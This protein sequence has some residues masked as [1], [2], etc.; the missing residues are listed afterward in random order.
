[1]IQLIVDLVTSLGTG[2]QGTFQVLLEGLG[3]LSS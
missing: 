1:M 2:L 3:G